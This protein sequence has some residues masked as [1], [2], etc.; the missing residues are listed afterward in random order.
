MR[1]SYRS[2]LKGLMG[3][4]VTGGSNSPAVTGSRE[5][6]EKFGGE[7]EADRWGP[8]GSEGEGNWDIDSGK[9]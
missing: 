2:G 8:P 5:R 9:E 1:A 3:R 6:G 4:G 7:D